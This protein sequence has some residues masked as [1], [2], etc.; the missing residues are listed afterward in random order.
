MRNFH[1]NIMSYCICRLRDC[2]I[3]LYAIDQLKRIDH[4]TT[5]YDNQGRRKDERARGA[6]V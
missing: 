3:Y 4:A 2:L 6:V 1:K 5:M